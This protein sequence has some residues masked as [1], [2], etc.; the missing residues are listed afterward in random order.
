MEPARVRPG[1]PTRATARRSAV[2][3]QWSRPEFGRV[4]VDGYLGVEGDK[5]PQ[6]SRPE[7]R[8]IKPVQCYLEPGAEVLQ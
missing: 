3:P 8:P 2:K 1:D 4:T 7:V 6:W 5:E